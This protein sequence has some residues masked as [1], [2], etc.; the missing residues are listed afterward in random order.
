VSAVDELTRET[1]GK[2]LVKTKHSSYQIDLDALTFIRDPGPDV[3][4]HGLTEQMRDRITDIYCEVGE[5]MHVTSG[6]RWVR[7]TPVQSIEPLPEAEA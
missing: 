4:G 6:D 2:W 5:S 7:S 3:P 1:G